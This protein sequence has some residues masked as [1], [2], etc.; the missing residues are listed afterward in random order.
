MKPEQ[1]QAWIQV[2][3]LLVN[4]GIATFSQIRNTIKTFNKDTTEA[5]MDAIIDGV[6]HDATRRKAIAEREAAGG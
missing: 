4:T 6:I 3:G 1:I 5:E 2:T